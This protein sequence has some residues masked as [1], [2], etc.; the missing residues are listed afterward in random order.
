MSKFEPDKRHLREVLIF[1]FNCKKTAAEACRM[2]VAAY[3]DCAPSDKTCR[4]WF[5]RFKNGDF[6]VV[7]KQRSG[8]PQV[9]E[10]EDLKALVDEDPCETQKQ[11]AEALNCSQ[12]VISDHLRALGKV[13]KE[14]KWVPYELKPRD[15]EKR[16]TI[17][18]ILLGRQ[19]RTG[20]L[21]RIIIGDKKWIYW[22]RIKTQH[23]II[24]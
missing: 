13:Y 20:F 22:V 19:Q 3:G 21:H 8:R 14:G 5:R 1:C 10:D 11:I 23:Q 12:S 9:F 18:E 6:T 2:L 16:K 15:I 7:D 4:E 17:C 24:S